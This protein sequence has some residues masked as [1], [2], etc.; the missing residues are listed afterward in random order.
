MSTPATYTPIACAAYDYL[1]ITAMHREPVQLVL[2][3]GTCLQAV[4]C[5]VRVR[6]QIEYFVVECAG[7]VQEIRLDQLVS[8][9]SLAQPPRFALIQIR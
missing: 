7:A 6:E 8:I 1:E 5:D 9:E 2:H 4:A 3:D